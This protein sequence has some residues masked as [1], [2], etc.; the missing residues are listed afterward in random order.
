MA[1]YP[2]QPNSLDEIMHEERTESLEGLID[3]GIVLGLGVLASRYRVEGRSKI[4]DKAE[5]IAD[6]IVQRR[7]ADNVRIFLN[8]GNHEVIE[9]EIV[10]TEQGP[11]E[12]TDKI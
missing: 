9:G 11:G 6:R 2:E 12:I 10:N 1:N 7:I 3:T 4:A 8:D 5:E